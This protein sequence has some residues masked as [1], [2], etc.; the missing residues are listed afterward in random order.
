MHV[1]ENASLGTSRPIF[2]HSKLLLL[3]VNSFGGATV[4]FSAAQT[5]QIKDP[6]IILDPWW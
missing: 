2:R 1:V 5:Q 3:A 6:R 4:M